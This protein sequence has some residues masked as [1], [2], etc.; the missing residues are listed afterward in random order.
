MHDQPGTTRDTVDTVVDTPEGPHPLRRHRRAAPARAASRRAVRVLRARPRPRGHRPRRR[1][2]ARHRRHRGRH[3]PGPA[4]RRAGRRRRQPGIVVV[5]NKWDLLDGE[6]SGAATS[7]PTSVTGSGSSAT[8]RCSRSPRSPAA[9]CPHPARPPRGRDGLP[10]PRPDRRAQQRRARGPG[11]HPPARAA[12][13]PASSTPSRARPT[14]RPSPC[15]PP[16]AP[17]HLPPLPRARACASAS[18]SARPPQAAGPSPQHLTRRRAARPARAVW[19]HQAV[20]WCL[21]CDRYL[22]PPTVRA[23]GTCPSCGQIVDA[24]K[25]RTPRPRSATGASPD[26]TPTRKPHR[27]PGTSSSSSPSPST[28]P[29]DS[30]KARLAHRP[31]LT[32]QPADTI[33]TLT[34]CGAVGLARR[35]GGPKVPGS[36]PGSPTKKDHHCVVVLLRAVTPHQ[37]ANA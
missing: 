32:G 13:S 10:P 21:H 4:A 16:R 26:R 27:S 9:A 1:R 19:S 20:P 31:H 18:S 37:P 7:S 2:P 33:T 11:R 8:R 6:P 23:N 15:S 30:S 34:G 24:G 28:S 29:T 17:S 36:S 5:L 12:P 14:R 3:P 22:T 35:S 25:A